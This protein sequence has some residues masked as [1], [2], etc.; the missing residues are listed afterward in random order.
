MDTRTAK[1]EFVGGRAFID[2]DGERLEPYFY[3]L[4]HSFAGRCS[5][6]PDKQRILADMGQAGVRLFQVDTYFED[7]WFEDQAELDLTF[8]QRMVRGVLEAVPGALVVLRIHVNAPFWWNERHPEEC[9]Q[10]ADGPVDWEPKGD[11]WSHESGDIYRALRASLVSQRW[12]HEAGARLTEF[13]RRFSQTPEGAAIVGLHVAGGI[14]GEWHY[15]GAVKHEPDTGPAMQSEFRRWTGQDAEVPGMELRTQTSLGGFRSPQLQ[16]E[17]FDYLRCQMNGVVDSIE[18]F[19][20]IVKREWPTSILTGVFYGYFHMLFC[21]HSIIGHL[22]LEPVLE[23]PVVDYLSAPQAYWESSRGLGGSGISRGVVDTATRFGKLWLD[24]VDHG[25][26]RKQVDDPDYLAVCRRSAWMPLLRGQGF[27]W[28]DFGIAQGY[29]GWFGGPKALAQVAKDVDLLR[30]LS[31]EPF[32]PVADVL[33]VWDYESTLYTKHDWWMVAYGQ[34]DMATEDLL[35]T[36]ASVEECYLFELP[37]VE[38][39]RFRV[40]VFGNSHC[41]TPEQL[42]FIRTRVAAGG[43]TLVFSFMPGIADGARLDPDRVTEVTGVATADRQ[44][45]TE[46]EMEWVG[47]T[48]HRFGALDPIRTIID[49][50]VEVLGRFSNDGAVCCARKRFSTHQ[51]VYCATPLL[52]TSAYREIFREAGCHLYQER[53]EPIWA[54]D[55]LVMLHTAAGGDR[56]L[57]LR[58]GLEVRV[59]LPGPS[60]VVLDA[61]T[62]EVLLG[63]GQASGLA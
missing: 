48:Q 34:I 8:A 58:N 22:C 3:A 50:D 29:P 6:E 49:P 27:W 20:G 55:R 10:F 19:C 32:A 28:Y 36:G 35:R 13:C 4:T 24:E 1:V 9:T 37:K 26:L 7:I 41:L 39:D 18:Y 17:L 23:S 56:R 62:G 47:G 31:R 54:N 52:G 42:E 16:P 2:V 30:E 46:V 63:P 51:V 43:R 40:V 14:F 11:E 5:W 33:V 44:A 15:W 45:Q 61:S 53:D 38:L 21:R 59:H 25:A 12:R 60:T 57:A